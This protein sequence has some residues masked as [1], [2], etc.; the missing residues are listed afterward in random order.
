MLRKRFWPPCALADAIVCNL[1]W[2][3]EHTECALRAPSA[4]ARSN[5]NRGGVVVVEPLHA[6]AQAHLLPF[7]RHLLGDAVLV[8]KARRKRARLVLARLAH[9]HRGALPADLLVAG[10]GRVGLAEIL[11]QAGRDPLTGLDH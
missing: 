4:S 7:A 1:A 11:V 3:G 2:G 6:L 8:G 10:E 5:R 9:V